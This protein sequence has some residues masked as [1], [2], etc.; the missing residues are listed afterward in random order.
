MN[1]K[2]NTN[3]VTCWWV[4]SIY[5]CTHTIAFVTIYT[6]KNIKSAIILV[7]NEIGMAIR[8]S[9]LPSVLFLTLKQTVYYTRTV[10]SVAT[11]RG[12]S[13]IGLRCTFSHQPSN[14]RP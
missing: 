4:T 6:S 1:R 10:N 8:S 9:E 14:V 5:Y 7:L 2:V 3:L 12:P 13:N 11:A